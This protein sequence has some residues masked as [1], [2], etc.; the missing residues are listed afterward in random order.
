MP[1]PDLLQPEQRVLSTLEADGRRR[2]LTPRLAS[3]RFL[4]YR[5]IVA[6]SLIAVFTLLP[7]IP[8]NGKPAI[9]LDVIKRRFTFFGTT[10]LPTDTFLLALF[11]VGLLV[12]IFLITALF[13][14]VWCGWACPQTVYL[15]F[16]YRPIERLFTGTA[17]KGGRPRNS[18]AGWRRIA[19]YAAFLLI[20]MFLAHTFLAYFVGVERLFAWVQGSPTEHPVAFLVMA[21]TTGLM[22]FDFCY[23]REQLCIIGCPYGRFQSVMLDRQSLIITY[24]PIRGEPRGKLR[25]VGSG[26]SRVESVGSVSLPTLHC[27][28]S[29]SSRGDCIDCTMCVQVCPTGIDIRDGLQLECVNCAQCIDA[30]DAVMDRIGKPRGLIRYSSQQA[31]EGETP[32]LLRP[33]VVLYP[34][35]IALIVGIFLFA[36]GTKSVA[37]VSLLRARGLPYYQMPEGRI[38]ST[39][40]VQITNRLDQPQTF[41]LQLQQPTP[42]RLKAANN[43]ITVASGQ[44]IEQ[45]VQIIA[46]REAFAGGAAGVGVRVTSPQ[47]Y[48][49]TTHTRLVGPTGPASAPA[50][51]SAPAPGSGEAT[52]EGAMP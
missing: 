14:R 39:L 49:H 17:G 43:P 41:T 24:D 44:T 32:R 42:M 12:S 21:A 26:A 52:I 46:P 50:P 36:L 48:D 31:V 7:Y 19:M 35:V 11:M 13:G 6:Y 20:S 27:P 45:P 8:I 1:E 10:F 28:P 47:G 33:R 38:G 16:V 15:E 4:K 25:R 40:R 9:L 5:R 23:W 22:M 2:W 3:G 29:T 37:N 30:C 51:R 18:V 34:M